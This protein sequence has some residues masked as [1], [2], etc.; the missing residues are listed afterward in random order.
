M[1]DSASPLPE[2]HPMHS[3]SIQTAVRF[4]WVVLLSCV[5]TGPVFADELTTVSGEHLVGKA[6]SANDK[7]I[8]FWSPTLGKIAL[9]RSNV[10]TITMAPTIATS[11]VTRTNLAALTT[12]NK[13]L[14]AVLQSL[15]AHP[16]QAENVTNDLLA[17]ARPEATAKFN[18][19]LR[20]LLS[21]SMSMADLR[22]EARTVRDQ[23]TDLRKDLGDEAGGILD[24]YISILD[25]FLA[26]TPA[27]QNSRTNS[28]R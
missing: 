16:E 27:A 18:Q 3:K 13:E 10:V 17:Q 21:G 8:V 22:N 20:G 2:A 9:A 11:T 28:A 1:K 5:L 12:T 6:V 4:L 19:M 7:T 25:K 15:N 24:S 26:Q 14:A 23:A